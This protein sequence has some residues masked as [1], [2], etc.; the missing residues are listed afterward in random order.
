MSGKPG[1]YIDSMLTLGEKQVGLSL[2]CK[3]L[4]RGRVVDDEHLANNFT[5]GMTDRSLAQMVKVGLRYASVPEPVFT[6]YVGWAAD[7]GCKLDWSAVCI[8]VSEDADLA[9]ISVDTD[10][11]GN[12]LL[13]LLERGHDGPCGHK[14]LMI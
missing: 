10:G 12:V 8:T 5:P 9:T 7:H 6:E 13:C 14:F 3:R 4:W 1:W 11:D 2:G